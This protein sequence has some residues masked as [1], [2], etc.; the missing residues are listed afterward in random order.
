[1]SARLTAEQKRIAQE[2]VRTGRVS[3]SKESSPDYIRAAAYVFD[4]G[5]LFPHP[6]DEGEEG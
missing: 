6:R 2:I 4:E 1:M 5:L 3:L